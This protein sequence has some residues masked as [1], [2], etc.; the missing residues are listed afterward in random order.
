MFSTIE[1]K[2]TLEACHPI[3]WHRYTVIY[4]KLHESAEYTCHGHRVDLATGVEREEQVDYVG[5][6]LHNMDSVQSRGTS[7]TIRYTNYLTSVLQ[8]C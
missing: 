3:L 1:L 5:L 7:P 6:L 2:K 8:K 4:L